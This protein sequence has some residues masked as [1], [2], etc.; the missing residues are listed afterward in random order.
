MKTE[1]LVSNVTA[2]GS[3][4]RAENAVRETI[5]GVFWPI[6]AVVVVGPFWDVA[7]SSRALVLLLR[8]TS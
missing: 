7:Y 2:V 1:W 4:R 6:E 8:I 3:P 5:S